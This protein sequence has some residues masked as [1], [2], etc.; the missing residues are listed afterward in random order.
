MCQI[1]YLLSLSC[2]TAYSRKFIHCDRQS[3][4]GIPDQFSFFSPDY[5]PGG[6]HKD[7]GL[8]SPEAELLSTNQI[9][10]SQNAYYMFVQLGLSACFGG[11]GPRW[12][13][14]V[15]QSCG[16]WND[17]SYRNAV[18]CLDY[19]PSTPDLS[20]GAE[21]IN[22]LN[23]ILTA[24]RLSVANKALIESAYASSYNDRGPE[25]ALQVAQVLMLT[26]SFRIDHKFPM[27]L[28]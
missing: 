27:K 10:S 19:S 17:R 7:S 14:G 18:A 13:R 1:K 23:T 12:D 22:E 5:S 16:S 20:D 8:V 28:L 25:E 6:A 11:I 21:V 24:N 4:Y 9:V 2:S 15:F 3:P 26:V